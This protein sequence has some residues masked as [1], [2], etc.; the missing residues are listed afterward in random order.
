MPNRRKRNFELLAV[1]LMLFSTAL[2]SHAA[3]ANHYTQHNLVSDIPGIADQTDPN[4]VNPWGISMSSTSPFWISNN[5]TGV[6][7]VYNGQG[8][9]TPAASPLVVRIPTPTGDAQP[10]APTGQVFNDT[11]GF[12][13]SGQPAAFI[14]ATED[15]TI[16]GWSPSA[17]PTNSIV[18]VDNST[19]GAVYKGLAVADANNGPMLYAA[20]FQAGTVDVFDA[21][22]TPVISTGAFTDTSLPSG[23]APFNIQR[24]GRK[25]YVTYAMQDQAKHDDV[26]G[27]GNGFIDI[28]DFNGNLLGRLVSNGALNSPWGLA[29]A[30]GNFG[31]FSNALLVGNFG[32]GK[33]NA[34]DPCSGEYLGS[35]DD[36]SGAAL[37]ISGL[38]ALSFGNGRGAGDANTLYFTA[39]IA[40][41][42][43]VEDHGLFGS[44]QIA[45]AAPAQSQPSS[46]SIVN[47]AFMP[48]TITIAAG[49]Q[50]QWTN[51]DGTGHTVTAADSRFR[52]DILNRANFFPNVQRSGHLLLSLLDS[53]L[54]EGDDSRPITFPKDRLMFN[55]RLVLSFR[56]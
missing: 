43:V 42:G 15:G 36:G 35:L 28:F 26:A 48:S 29:M 11:A 21:N 51:Q 25:L 46:A 18:L 39:G 38:W 1:F 8:Q 17:S 40:G 30:P 53:S 23:F 49:A 7:A 37:T 50:V 20:N 54:H 13:V 4:L 6:A 24:I 9:P 56:F 32:D 22:L 47:F 41:P 12:N 10:A 3:G 52:S 34:F 16:S 31:D 14:F 2:S 5:H 27:V 33:I 19:L 45:D 55:S 44:I